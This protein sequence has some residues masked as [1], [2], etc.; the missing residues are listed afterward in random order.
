VQLNDFA[1]G[2]RYMRFTD[3]VHEA[4]ATGRRVAL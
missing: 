1:T 4:D 3:A 2:L